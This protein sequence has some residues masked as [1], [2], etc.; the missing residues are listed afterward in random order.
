MRLY[1]PI[2]RKLYQRM[3]MLVIGAVWRAINACD[4]P[5]DLRVRIAR[6]LRHSLDV[7]AP[8]PRELE[9]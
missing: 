7:E 1:N 4:V 9:A 3:R 2:E 5:Y 6:E 8:K